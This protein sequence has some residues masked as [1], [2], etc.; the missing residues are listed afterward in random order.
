VL[1]DVCL[2]NL[3]VKLMVD[4]A[5]LVG[6][7]GETHQGI[8]DL[9]FLSVVPNMTVLSPKNRW[10]MADMVRFAVE[11]ECPVALRYPRGEAYEGL[12]QFR[13]PIKYG[14]SEV[15]YEE[16]EIALLFV[17]HMAEVAEEVWGA[18]KEEGFSCSLVN[19]RFVKPLDEGMIN[20]LAKGH[21][22]LVTIEENVW[23]GGYGQQ[24]QAYVS[25]RD[26]PLDVLGIA[27]PD[28]YVEHGDV[29]ILRREVGLEKESIL[30]RVKER[31]SPGTSKGRR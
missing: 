16:G 20:Q 31:L 15:L 4:R 19:V 30:R 7:D 25:E 22:L 13:A 9:S 12:R 26:L 11:L 5:G 18:L 24:V 3:P 17:G 2:Q 29:N 1:H 8:F 6:S 28:E 21:R 10:E 27:I 14:K 23:T